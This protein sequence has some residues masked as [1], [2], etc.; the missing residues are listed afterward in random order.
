MIW[1]QQQAV[2]G[3]DA[4]NPVHRQ[5]LVVA[6]IAVNLLALCALNLEVGDYFHRELQSLAA[7]Y[8]R[9]PPGAYARQVRSLAIARD[10]SYSAVWMA[11]GVLLMC[12][13]FWKRAEFLRWQAIVLIGVTILKVFIYD[14][15]AL[16]RGYRILAFMILGV[17]LL[18]ISYAYQKDWLGLQKSGDG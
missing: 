13:G 11:Y 6:V 12:V 5:A 10:F 16:Q 4:H 15:S 17:I 9:M 2:R 7:L 18:A 14:A 1:W 3:A 8:R